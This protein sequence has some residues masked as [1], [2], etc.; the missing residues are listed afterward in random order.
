LIDA[1]SPHHVN[2]LHRVSF[3]NGDADVVV[4]QQLCE[5]LAIDQDDLLLNAAD[6]VPGVLTEGGW[7]RT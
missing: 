5:L 2:P 1:R 3:L 7:Y 4:D 6:E